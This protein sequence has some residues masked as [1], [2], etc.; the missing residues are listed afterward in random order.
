MATNPCS[1]KV[2]CDCTDFPISNYSSEGPEQDAVYS[3]LVFPSA[4]WDSAGCLTVC[5]SSVSQLEAD[6]CALAQQAECTNTDAGGGTGGDNPFGGARTSYLSDAAYCVKYCPDGNPFSVTVPSHIAAAQTQ[7]AANALAQAWACQLASRYRVC[8]TSL[9]MTEC[10]VGGS[11]IALFDV[12]GSG[13]SPDRNY[14]QLV[15]GTLPPG[16][17]LLY[18][19]S[20]GEE[21]NQLIGVPETG[22]TYLFTIRA[23]V[24]D[25]SYM[26]KVF[27]VCILDL[28]ST[29]AG[30][31][32][33]ALPDATL[34]TAYSCQMGL[35]GIPTPSTGC[36]TGPRSWQVTSG[37]LPAGLALDE[38]TGVISGTPTVAGTYTFTIT[39][40]T[41]AS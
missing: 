15:S 3:A 23:T 27:R 41:E 20:Y 28:T 21:R 34:S 38:T 2:D 5:E 13:V 11:F 40:Q 12:I 26:Q 19:N 25:G 33:T 14:W 7:A 37:A 31:S 9:T 29:P 16:L 22:G 39:L 17:S 18:Q 35:V 36:G 30:S 1:I 6:L 8:I 10:C 32:A 4:S 24:P